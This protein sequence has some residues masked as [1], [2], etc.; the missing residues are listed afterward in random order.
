M[1]RFGT[2]KDGRVYPKDER[3]R[4]VE[5]LLRIQVEETRRQQAKAFAE[6]G[7]TYEAPSKVHGIGVFASRDIGAG[8]EIVLP[9]H[10]RG[11]NSSKNPNADR[12]SAGR[13]RAKRDIR[14]GSEIF[15][16]Y[17]IPEG[18]YRE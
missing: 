17:E 14:K 9:A 8:E 4:A 3:D 12:L 15:V 2:R 10:N 16:Y 13:A 6:R 7:N 11:F 5:E 18:E 1:L